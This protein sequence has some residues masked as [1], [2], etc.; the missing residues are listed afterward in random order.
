MQ[1]AFA[2]DEPPNFMTRGFIVCFPRALACQAGPRVGGTRR[3]HSTD[4]R[5]PQE[6]A[7]AMGGARVERAPSRWQGRVR[8]PPPY[9]T[10]GQAPTLETRHGERARAPPDPRPSRA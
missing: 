9:A 8:G 7:C 4:P 5:R 3:S 10:I 1:A 2:T 6:D